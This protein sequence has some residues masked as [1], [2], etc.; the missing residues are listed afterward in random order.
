[1][2]INIENTRNQSY[3]RVSIISGAKQGIVAQIKKLNWKALYTHCFGNAVLLAVTNYIIKIDVLSDVW[4]MIK[5]ICYFTKRLLSRLTKLA[6]IC[7][8]SPY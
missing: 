4:V 8:N 6:E 7:E 3:D 1:M 5:E 2:Y